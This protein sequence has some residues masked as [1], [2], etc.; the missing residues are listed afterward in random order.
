ML[1][2]GLNV[3]TTDKTTVIE[4][5]P[6]WL[7]KPKEHRIRSGARA[8]WDIYIPRNKLLV[9]GD[10]R[11]G[12]TVASGIGQ[13]SRDRSFGRRSRHSTVPI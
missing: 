3:L 12:W 8:D 2:Y 6:E 10:K 13:Y 7:L 5:D 1:F 4:P 11:L 9:D